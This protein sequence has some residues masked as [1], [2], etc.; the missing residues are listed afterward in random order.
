[1]FPP[2]VVLGLSFPLLILGARELDLFPG[3]AVGQLYF[4]S[5]IGA[6]IGAAVATYAFSRWIGTLRGLFAL[7]A[8]VITAAVLVLVW[9][10]AALWRRS[11]AG[12]AF[13]VVAFSAF[14]FPTSLVFLRD[15]ET[16]LD[17][18]E[19]EYG[20]HLIARTQSGT[21]RVRNNRLQLIY[22]LGHLQTSH[23]QQM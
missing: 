5:T 18:A 12:L 10:R 13:I 20:V 9:K 4:V 16:L 7:T 19:D 14:S 21:L 23:A 3:R 8:L 1:V 11:V 17:S 2:I 6:A 15:R 22:D